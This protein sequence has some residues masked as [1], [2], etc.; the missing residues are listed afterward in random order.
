MKKAAVSTLYFAIAAIFTQVGLY[1]REQ[2]ATTT[3]PAIEYPPASPDVRHP[4]AISIAATAARHHKLENLAFES[5]SMR[6]K[7]AKKNNGS[8]SLMSNKTQ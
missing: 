4:A 3:K 5:G 8:K 1:K 6:K 2:P 7:T